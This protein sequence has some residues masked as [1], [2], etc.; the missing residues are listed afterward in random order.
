MERYGDKE[1]WDS[2]T[3]SM[4]SEE[5]CGYGGFKSD[6]GSCGSAAD[7][8]T[9]PSQLSLDWSGDELKVP[10]YGKAIGLNSYSEELECAAK[11][12][13]QVYE[14]ETC[15]DDAEALLDSNSLDY[16][17]RTSLNKLIDIAYGEMGNNQNIVDEFNK[18]YPNDK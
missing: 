17:E 4:G 16:N 11:A 10:D 8:A 13:I 14:I 18:K 7:V 3:G 12:S 2:G 1:D 6:A 9:I 5:C 15:I